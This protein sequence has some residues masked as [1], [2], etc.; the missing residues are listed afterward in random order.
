MKHPWSAL[1]LLL[2]SVVSGATASPPDSYWLPAGSH[3][4]APAESRYRDDVGEVEVL[5]AGGTLDL[6]ASPFF[7]VLGRNGRA[8]VTCHQ[9][10]NA[11][12]LAVQT[13]QRRWREGGSKDP[14]F[15]PVDGANCPNLPQDQASSHSLLLSRGLFRV[16]LPWPRTVGPDGSAVVPEFSIEVVRDPTGC[17]TD[18]VYGLHSPNPRISVFR[19]PRMVA[20]LKYLAVDAGAQIY[21][22][23]GPFNAKRLAMVAD[24][25]PLTGQFSAM[26][27]MSDARAPTLRMQAEEA[28]REHLQVSEPLS[29]AQLQQ[30]VAFES[31]VYAAQVTDA[32]GDDFSNPAMPDALGA[33]NLENSR[34]GVLG[35]NFGNPAFKSF[36]VW[37][38]SAPAIS[39]AQRQ[40]RSSVMRGYQV[41]FNRAFW[42]RDV[43]HINTVGLGNPAKRTCVTCH[44]LQMVGTDAS[45]GWGDLGTSNEPWA[46]QA[47]FSPAYDSAPELP[48]FKVVC[49]PEARPHPFL[50]RVIYTH[51]PGRALISGK[52][53]DV[54][55]VVMGQLRGLAARPPYFANGTAED[56]RAVVDF[57]DRR[58]NIGLTEQERTDLV[59]FLSVL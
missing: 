46:D 8:C 56:L 24:R 6:A 7:Q 25:D 42:I 27:I 58:F 51:D 22:G 4:R 30:I 57:Y 55:S 28:A 48:L 43:T 37:Q 26:N 32:A 34:T 52:C 59:N 45:A 1:S 16:S 50:G 38:Q 35:D 29:A 49:R 47:L 21:G 36:A 40:F 9:P 41:F 54:G 13:V 39:P 33:R 10:A 3:A 18:P 17:N 5:F 20:N 23:A 44:N 53:Y 31:Q 15:A 2:A 12:G 19:R 14:L 11:M